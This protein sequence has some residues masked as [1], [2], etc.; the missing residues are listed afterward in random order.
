MRLIDSSGYLLLDILQR[1]TM[2]TIVLKNLNYDNRSENYDNHSENYANQNDNDDNHCDNRDNHCDKCDN[3]DNKEDT[4]FATI[5]RAAVKMM[6]I[7]DKFLT[8]QN[9]RTWASIL[10]TLYSW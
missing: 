5:M 7:L 9:M 10:E 3:L 1:L 4:L 2:M 8:V 6:L